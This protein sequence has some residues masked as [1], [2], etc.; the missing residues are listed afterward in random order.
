MSKLIP[1]Y[2]ELQRHGVRLYTWDMLD[3]KAATV[4][5]GGIYGIFVDFSNIT[6][7]ADELVTIAHEGGHCMTGATHKVCSPFDLVEKH[8]VKAWKYAVRRL[9]SE[10]ELDAAIADGHTELPD[11]ADHFGV[12]PEFMQKAVCLYTYGNLATELYF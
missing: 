5:I 3:E 10:E 1:L 6:S 2:N 12:T 4:E 11:L 9:I 8:E 7:A